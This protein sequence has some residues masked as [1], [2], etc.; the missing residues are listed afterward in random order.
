MRSLARECVFKYLFAKFFNSNNEGLFAVLLNDNNLSDS[1]KDFANELLNF[2]EKNYCNYCNKIED[3][4]LSFKLDRI[5]I[6]D[7]CSILIGFA[8]LDNYLDTPVPVIIDE[9]VKLS[10]IYSTEKSTDFVNGILAKYASEIKR[11]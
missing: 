5:F 1:D 7:K 3:L 4:S 10:A 2:I 6:A 11:C 9:A 8:E